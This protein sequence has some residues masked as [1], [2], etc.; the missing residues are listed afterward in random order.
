MCTGAANR[1]VCYFKAGQLDTALRDARAATTLCPEYF[2]GQYR[3][4]QAL[5]ALG[6]EQEA[7]TQEKK[8][9]RWAVT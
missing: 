6:M 1:A 8:C 2:K 9:A 5:K 4:A 3:L 7:A